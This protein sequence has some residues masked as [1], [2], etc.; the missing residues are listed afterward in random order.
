M[1]ETEIY[2][3]LESFYAGGQCWEFHLCVQSVA[4]M[5]M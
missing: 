3:S 2:E 1:Q 5:L 4:V